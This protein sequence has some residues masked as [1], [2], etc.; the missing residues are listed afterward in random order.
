M[1]DGEKLKE[2]L[3]NKRKCGWDIANE[4]EKDEIYKFGSEYI[5]YLNKCKTER[6]TISFSK[7]I[8]EENRICRCKHKNRFK[9]RR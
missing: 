2:T 6:E 3:F 5:H 8:L 1:S 7:E 9:T 4:A